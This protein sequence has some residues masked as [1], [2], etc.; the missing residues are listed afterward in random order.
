MGIRANLPVL[1]GRKTIKR[2]SLVLAT[3]DWRPIPS[4]RYF[5]CADGRIM[6]PHGHILKPTLC[7]GY[8]RVCIHG[9]ARPINRL[10]C[11]AFHGAPPTPEHEAAHWD[12]IRTNNHEPNVRWAT[13]AENAADRIRHGTNSAGER[14]PTAILTYAAVAEIRR[15]YETSMGAKYVRRGTREALAKKHG[16]SISTIKDV[17]AGNSWKPQFSF[18]DPPFAVAP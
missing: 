13:P 14:N 12:G 11:E 9:K 3:G 18:A 7:R 15:T 17:V 6:G 8:L 2:A 4:S 16:V 5:A 10:I 1:F